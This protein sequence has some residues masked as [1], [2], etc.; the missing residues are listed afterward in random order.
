MQGEPLRC[1]TI[2]TP[3]LV[4][5]RHKCLFM[6]SEAQVTLRPFWAVI[7][8]CAQA[9]EVPM[10]RP[11]MPSSKVNQTNFRIDLS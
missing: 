2:C 9:L 4:S 11:W 8:L 5:T 6:S 1:L 10:A 7:P 3:R